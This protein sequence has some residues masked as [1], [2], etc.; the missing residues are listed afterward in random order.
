ML[1]EKKYWN[2][3]K[4]IYLFIHERHTWETCVCLDLASSGKKAG[5]EPDVGLNPRTQDHALS[6]R[7]MLN[8]WA[9]QVPPQVLSLIPITQ[10]LHS[11]TE[12]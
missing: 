10:L 9:T 12:L 1:K 11:P 4:K 6:Q 2:F 3:F 8:H 7:Q 5:I